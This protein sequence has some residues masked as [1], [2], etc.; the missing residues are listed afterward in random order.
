MDKDTSRAPIHHQPVL[1]QESITNLRLRKGGC[2]IDAT[3][4][5]GGHAIG[6]LN[7]IAPDGK[8][9][10][11]DKDQAAI[12][13]CHQKLAD[14]DNRVLLVKASYDKMKNIIENAGWNCTDG[15][16]FDLGV[17]SMQFDQG[18]RGFSFS[19]DAPLD[20]RFDQDQEITGYDIINQSSEVD[21]AAIIWN[22]GEDPHARRIAAAIIRNRPL[23]STVELS[24]VI[25]RAYGNHQRGR[26]HPATRTFQ[27]LRMAVNK[28][29]ETLHNGLAQALDCLCSQGRLVVISFHSLEDRLVKHFFQRE[30]RD[31]ICPPDQP[32]CQC[33]HQ[34][35]IKVITR[36]PIKPAQEEVIHNPRAR[37]AKLRAAEKI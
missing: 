7:A 22:F 30:S 3:I 4:G 15:I 2:Y 8:L 36:H 26:I 21:L 34:A 17:S 25:S 14:L 11:L 29:L 6:I 27:A 33:G 16:L 31:C 9:I 32:I 18:E 23:H 19:K 28:E 5:A 1:Y 12:D 13:I 20:M 24:N 35:R 37:S 10:G